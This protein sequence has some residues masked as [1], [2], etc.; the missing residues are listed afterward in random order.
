M[1]FAVIA[2]Q[3]K[4][5]IAQI[6]VVFSLFLVI[7]TATVTIS[8]CS[9]E[10]WNNPYPKS[11]SQQNIYYS[12][13]TERPKHLDPAQS[14][15]SNE[16]VFTG[17][18]Y[19]P[20]LQYHFLDRPYEL[21]PLTAIA[22]PTPV[23]VD[24]DNN[25]LPDN[26]SV[27]QIA[28]SVYTIEIQPGIMY[29]P[30]PAF[31]K[32][33][34]GQ[35]LYLDLSPQQVED[36]FSLNDFAHSGTRELV[37]DDYVHE[38]KRLANPRIHS[39]I[40][41][42]MSE[43]IVGLS[44]YGKH[45]QKV[46]KQL[47]EEQGEHAYLD[48]SQHPLEGVKVLGRYKYQIKIYGKYPQFLY[49][50]AMPFFAP[51]P[52]E[53]DQFYSQPGLDKKNVTLD[54]YPV[55]TGPYLLSENNPNM[56]MVMVKNPNFHGELYPNSG[57]PGDAAAGFLADAN[58]PLPFIDKAVYS[59]EKESIPA[60]N[61]FLQGYYDISGISSDSFDQAISFNTQG[62]VGLSGQMRDK[63]IELV[64]GVG[65]ST[66]YMGFNML[67]PVVGGLSEDKRKLRQAISIAIDY[68]E[69]ISIFVNGRGIPAQG[70]I[71]P[72][73]FGYQEGAQGINPYVYD[74]VNGH[75]QRKS[76]GYAK[77]LLAEAGY[78]DG[79]E[80]KTGKPLT[81]F[82]DTTATGPDDKAR[83]D[84]FRK[85]FQKLNIQLVVR[86]TDYNRFQDKMLKG[87]AQF[88]QWGW[89][90]DYPDPENFLFLLYGPNMKKDKNGENAANYH[91]TEFDR[92]FEKV[93]NMNNGPQRQQIINDM[94]EIV[95]K[96]SPW[97]WGLH[98][99]QFTLYHSWY[100]NVKPNL[101]ANNTLKYKRIDPQKRAK[102]RRQWNQPV[103]W[104]IILTIVILVI[105]VI[106][107]VNSYRAKIHARGVH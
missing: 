22:V 82:F 91:N 71:P 101:M 47:V 53:V 17:Q 1:K 105:A 89:N 10:P 50:L 74:W 102:L 64:T 13:F 83:M 56:R 24:A 58:K 94:M 87:T 42:L 107:A 34:N 41:G 23:F 3:I 81:I 77:Q 29:Q 9:G 16:I 66:Y 84:W 54:W 90:A 85:Q 96:D 69:F 15:S 40:F 19:E 7:L 20:P 103:T 39:P 63:G 61:K 67:D 11:Q 78:P 43:Y 97:V 59:L 60:W 98:P 49:W 28:F 52:P 30:H 4:S 31:A 55:G 6:P 86:G 104:P 27:D 44:E 12:T 18:I 57:E 80:E 26:V 48:L 106:P 8:G 73:I 68:E 38:I 51:I 93:K 100:H 99:K 62:E 72:G 5:T 25:E 88:F 32:D 65:T 36:T 92:L 70:P 33:E 35:P 75:P 21:I 37:A 14:Y 46:N 45:L 2:I 79:R 76:I 95:R